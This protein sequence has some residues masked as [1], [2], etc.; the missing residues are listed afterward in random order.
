MMKKAIQ[1]IKNGGVVAAPTDTV[2]GLLADATNP[3]AIAKIYALKGRDFDKPL[4]IIVSPKTLGKWG[5]SGVI[6]PTAQPTTYIV[7]LS[8]ELPEL[9]HSPGK[10]VA[11]RLEV[12]NYLEELIDSV[13]VPLTATSANKSGDEP[14]LTRLAALEIGADLTLADD[15]I[16]GTGVPSAIVVLNDG[17]KIR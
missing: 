17:K 11:L 8:G 16:E 9:L 15:L 4:P 1:T 6:T 7:E 5:L 3:A 13:G 10:T 14:A 12:G 2:Y